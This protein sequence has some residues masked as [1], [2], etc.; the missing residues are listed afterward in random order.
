MQRAKGEMSDEDQGRERREKAWAD[1]TGRK[2]RKIVNKSGTERA[3]GGRIGKSEEGEE[4][5]STRLGRTTSKV[6]EE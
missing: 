2:M 5:R 3:R 1:G 4:S 6:S